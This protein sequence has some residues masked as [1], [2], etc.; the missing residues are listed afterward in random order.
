MACARCSSLNEAEFTGEVT[1]HFFSPTRATM[2]GV[3]TFPVVLVC[4][5]CGAAGLM[6]Q[7][8]N[9]GYCERG[10]DDLRPLNHY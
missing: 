2:L 5:D 6:R 3:S 4:L 1:L 10:P 7:P 8:R 9:C